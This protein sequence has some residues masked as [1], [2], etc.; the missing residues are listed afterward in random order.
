MSNTTHEQ[1][2]P[3]IE[4]LLVKALIDKPVAIR[5][6]GFEANQRVTLRVRMGQNWAAYAT[7][8]TDAQ[9]VAN[10]GSQP[11][12][13]G[14]YDR[15]DPMLLQPNSCWRRRKGVRSGLSFCIRVLLPR[16]SSFLAMCYSKT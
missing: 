11:P 6:H 4:V 3:R 16:F 1:T 7:F 12:L 9:G 8:L 5:L 14:T 13:D 15:V 2:V 10:G